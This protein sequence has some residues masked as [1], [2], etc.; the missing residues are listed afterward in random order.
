MNRD[1]TKTSGPDWTNIWLAAKNRLKREV[2]DAVYD[3]WLA[4][5]SLLSFEKSEL[6]IAA[7]RLYIRNWVANQYL[8]RIERALRAEGGEPASISIVLAPPTVGGAL[9][10]ED[11]PRQAAT[12]SPLPIAARAA[13]PADARRGLFRREMAPAQ[14]FESF[15]AG[16]TN[17]FVHAAARAFALGEASA[18]DVP[19]LYIH[20]TFGVGKTHLLNAITLAA[21]ARGRKAVLLSSESFMCSFLGALRS[22]E[23]LE[24]KE[25]VRS[26]E[27]LLV[28][29]LQHLCRSSY[30]VS[31]FLHTLNAFSDLRRKFV[32]A[33]DRA[34]GALDG[35][36]AEVRSRLSG[37]LVL[38]LEKPD[39][40]TRLA[41]LK[42]RAAGVAKENNQIAIPDSAL[43]RIADIEDTTP[44]D[45]IGLFSKLAVYAGVTKN[46]GSADSILNTILRGEPGTHRISIEE[47]Q[48]KAAEFYHLDLRDFVSKQRS[49]RVARPRQ[50]AMYLS[51]QLTERSL[52]E[53]GKHFGGRDHT[54]VLHAC[55]R[56]EAL[57][58]ADPMFRHE[59]EFLKNVLNRTE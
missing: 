55:R 41:I 52:P 24:F 54:T 8:S 34:P 10:R 15:I 50:I 43:G 23:T 48:R 57:C 12:V 36:S 22:K 38:G 31:E 26:A 27:M 19:L 53:I 1:N 4:Q 46:P 59:I 47:I 7:P 51:R 32:I 21:R 2:G 29:D 28:D 5:L 42:S 16:G 56:I 39:H 49:R 35:L 6:R 25:E 9:P 20:G 37:G 18:A 13:E 40:A 11:V 14:T 30:T 33:A 58:N 17:E 44:R 3:A 45:I